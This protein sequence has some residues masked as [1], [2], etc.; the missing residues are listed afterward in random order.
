MERG[1]SAFFSN[2]TEIYDEKWAT[3]AGLDRLPS[4]DMGE[5]TIGS[6]CLRKAELYYLV[7]TLLLE[8]CY[9]ANHAVSERATGT[10]KDDHQWFFAVAQQADTFVAKLEQIELAIADEK[11]ALPDWGVDG[12]LWKQV[13]EA[14][15]KAA[16]G[17]DD[18]RVELLRRRAEQHL[19]RADAVSADSEDSEDGEQSE[20][21]EDDANAVS[22]QDGDEDGERAQP[23]RSNGN[24]RGR[25]SRTVLDD[26][27]QDE[28]EEAQSAADSCAPAGAARVA[29]GEAGNKRKQ[30]AA[31]TVPT[32]RS[33]RVQKLAPSDELL[34]GPRE[35]GP[36]EEGLREEG[37]REEEE[38]LL[39]AVEAD[40]TGECVGDAGSERSSDLSS[41]TPSQG[42]RCSR[43]RGG[44]DSERGRADGERGREYATR[45]GS[46][47]PLPSAFHMA[48]EQRA[49]GTRL[50]ARRRCLFNLG[51]LQLRLLQEGR[52]ADSAI[53]TNA[54]FTIQE[55]L[56]R[57]EQ[58]AHTV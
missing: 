33:R 46:R 45:T 21:Q 49:P 4:Q 3:G 39:E 6:T 2:Y 27:E 29:P 19:A 17:D 26:S 23:R 24:F 53:C 35:E 5:Y 12:L 1:W 7:N 10:E 44:A 11:R 47:A 16:G 40:S 28:D 50:P 38:G 58:L 52:D 20:H 30:R 54:M 34:E 37:L 14:R 8:C 56:A 15:T 51:T 31:A 13:D 18:T 22:E 55:L 42:L 9:E 41:L 25:R 32:R 43:E 48:Q 36:R 57:V